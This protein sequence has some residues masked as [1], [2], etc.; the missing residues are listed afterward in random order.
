[1]NDAQVAIMMGS[2]SDL[3]V[4]EEAAKVLKKFK[5]SYDMKVLSAHRTPKETATYVEDLKDSS[6]KVIICG[7]GVSAATPAQLI[8]SRNAVASG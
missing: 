8:A 5:V 7:A 6:V 4:M 2:K 1:M 3:D